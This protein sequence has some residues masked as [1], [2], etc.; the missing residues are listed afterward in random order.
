MGTGVLSGGTPEREGSMIRSGA[1][2]GLYV[3]LFGTSLAIAQDTAPKL[4]P[5]ALLPPETRPGV[6][7]SEPAP[8]SPRGNSRIENRPLLVIPGVTAPA[9]LRS[10][11]R[12]VRPPTGQ[13]ETPATPDLTAPEFLG[14]PSPERGRATPAGPK[15]PARVIIPLTLEPIPEDVATEGEPEQ[16]P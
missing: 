4:D 2:R 8:T 15:D 1:A 7:A 6:A 5:P 3:L 16:A 9:R 14:N 11:T 13:A 10:G 12:P